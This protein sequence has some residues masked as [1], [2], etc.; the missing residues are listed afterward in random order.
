MKKLIAAVFVLLIGSCIS[1]HITPN[2]SYTYARST[3]DGYYMDNN[4]VVY[5]TNTITPEGTK[6]KISINDNGTIW[7][8]DDEIKVIYIFDRISGKFIDC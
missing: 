6:A 4:G 1:T 2:I 5:N 3:G 7:T 8:F